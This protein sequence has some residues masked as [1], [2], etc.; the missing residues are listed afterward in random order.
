MLAASLLAIALIQSPITVTGE[1]QSAS[2]SQTGVARLSSSE[3]SQLKIKAE[4]GEA[5]AQVKLA[6]AYQ[7]GNGV[8]RN[9]GLAAQWYRKA[10]EQG[11]PVA[12]NCLGNMYRIGTGVEKNNEAALN[13]YR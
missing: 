5:E 7:E 13:W 9:D 6:Q 1:D 4:S 2:A 12:Q 11:N 3:V 10:A 8:S